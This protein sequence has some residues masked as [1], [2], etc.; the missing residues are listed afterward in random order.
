MTSFSAQDGWALLNIYAGMALAIAFIYGLARIIRNA[1]VIDVFWGFGLGILAIVYV[2]QMPLNLLPI[3]RPAVLAGLAILASLRLGLYLM[4]RFLHEHPKEDAR[5]T[6]FR[7]QWQPRPELTMFGVYQLQGLLMVTVSLPIWWVCQ[8]SDSSLGV[9]DIAGM[10]VFT[11]GWLIEWWADDTLKRFKQEPSNRGKTCQSGLWRFSRHPNYFGEWLM[12]LGY[13]VIALNV[14]AGWV[15]IFSPLLM[16]LFLTKV[17]GVA[18]TEAHALKT[19]ADYAE[20]QRRTS[21]FFP[22]FVKG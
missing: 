11:V 20:Y 9:W 16:L 10:L 1:G 6:A 22:W 12:W 4:K 8:F 19:R 15:T 17:T 14:P 3:G 5:Y 2:L 21:P 18:A 7:Q 13:Y